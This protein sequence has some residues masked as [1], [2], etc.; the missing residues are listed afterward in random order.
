MT[1]L[2][3]ESPPLSASRRDCLADGR[4]R[5][6]TE[7]AMLAGVMPSTASVHL[8]RLKAQ[9]LVKVFAQGRHR[10][11]SLNGADV[12]VALE[13]LGV[14]A[15]CVSASCRIRLS[16]CASRELATITS[17]A[18]LESYFMTASTHWDG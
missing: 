15:G 10:Y 3:P 12:A 5:T 7:L 4:G 9:Q 6:S 14:L 17:P 1:V 16:T 13:A 11:Y 2:S 8:K 18:R